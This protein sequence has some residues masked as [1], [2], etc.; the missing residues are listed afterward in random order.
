MVRR[1]LGSER[2]FLHYIFLKIERNVL[3]FTVDQF[4][5]SVRAIADKGFAD[6]SSFWNDYMFKFVYEIHKPSGWAREFTPDEAKRVW[7]TLI[8]LKLRCP[9]VD[10]KDTLQQLE[11]FMPAPEKIGVPS[12]N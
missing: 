12:Q 5:R 4:C 10:L 8:Y 6:D 7:D 9:Q 11:K 1:E 3:K 2:L